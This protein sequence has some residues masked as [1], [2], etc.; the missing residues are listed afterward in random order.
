MKNST[1]SAQVANNLLTVLQGY[2]KGIR[3]IALLTLLLALGVTNAWGATYSLTPDKAQT[4]LSNT[5][6]ITS[7][8]SFTY[9]GVTWKMNQWNPSTL[10]IKTNQGSATSE[11]RFYNTSA[12]PGKIT[13]VVI[14]FSAMTVSDA[15]KLMFIGGT[16]E[17]TATSGGNAGTWN[18]SAKTLTWTPDASDNFTYFA[19]YQNGKAASGTNKLATSNAIVVTYETGES[20][21]TELTD[22]QFDWSAASAEATM[23]STF[24]NQPTLINTLGLSVS[25]SS[26]TPATATI[27][28]SGLVTLKAAGTT[29]ISATFAGGEVGGTTYA[30]KTVSY[31]LTVNP[32]PLVIEPIVGGIVDILTHSTFAATTNQ[33]TNFSGKQA[34]NDNHSDAVYAGKTARNGSATQYNIQLNTIDKGRIATTTTGGLAKRVYVRWA[35]Q[36]AN[37]NNRALYIYGS[38]DAFTGSETSTSATKIGTITFTTGAAEAYVDLTGDYKYILITGSG[39]IY[40]DEIH[41]TWVSAAGT[42]VTP[43]IHGDAEF[44][45]STEVSISTEDGY[46]VYYTLD[47]TEPTNASTEYTAPF[48]VDATTTVKAVAYDGATASDVVS[49]T[50]KKLQSLT[51]AEAAALC[52]STESTDKYVIRGY[53]TSI[54]YPYSATNTTPTFWM[55]DTKDGG[56]VMQAY[57][58]TPLEDADKEVIVGDQVE[59]IGKIKLYNSTPEVNGGTYTITVPNPKY[60]VNI[61]SAHG[62][63]TANPASAVEGTE[64]TLSVE[65]ESGWVFQSW[66]VTDASSNPIEV[67]DNKFTM[68]ASDVTVVANY[69]ES[70][71]PDAVLTL[72]ANGNQHSQE[73]YKVGET[74]ELPAT[75]VN[76]CVKQFVGWSTNANCAVAPEYAPGADFELTAT[77]HTLYA[78]YASGGTGETVTI[79]HNSSSTVNMTGENDANTY[80]GL[81]ANNWTIVSDKGAGSNHIG[82][83]KDGGMRLYYNESGSTTLTITAPSKVASIQ[84]ACA[85]NY[86]DALVKVDGNAVTPVDGVYAIDAETFVITNNSSTQVRIN[87]ITVTLAGAFTDYSTTCEVATPDSE[88]YTITFVTNGGSEVDP[89]TEQTAL[90]NPLPETTRSHYTFAGWYTDEG[91]TQAAVAGVA[92]TSNTT[93]YAKWTPITYTVS[94]DAGSGNYTS[95]DKT[96]NYETGITLPTATPCAYASTSGWSF[97][98]WSESTVSETTIRPVLHTGTYKPTKNIKLHAVYAKTEAGQGGANEFILSLQYES[99]TYYVGQTFSDSKLSAETEQANAAR[100]TIEDNYLHYEGGYISHVAEGSPNLTKKTD[101]AEAQGWTINEDGTNITFTSTTA[102]TS[103]LLAFHY[104][105][106]N[107]R[108]AA[109]VID[110][111]KY[112]YTFT[113]TSVSGGDVQVTTYNSNPSCEAPINPNWVDA[114]ISHAAIQVV[115]GSK[116]LLNAADP[117]GPATISFSGTDLVNP[118]TVTASSGFFVSTNKTEENTYQSEIT[119]NPHKE[120]GNIGK[121]QNVYVIAQA[122]AQSGNFTGTITLTGTDITD[123]SQV[124]KV[125]ADVTCTTYTITWSVNGDTKLIDPTT[126]YA[127]GDWT[128]PENPTYE[129]NGRE[130]VGWTTDEILQPQN[131]VPTTLYVEKRNF[132]T[133]ESDITFYAVFAKENTGDGNGTATVI[134]V[135]NRDLTGITETKYSN[136]S[137][138]TAT[139]SAVYAGNSA[140]GN[141]SIQL[142][143][144][145]SNSG[146][147]TTT[148]GGKAKEVTVVWNSNTSSGRT[149]NIYGKNS[150][151]SAATD[152]YGDNAG[153]LIGSITYNTSTTI[154]IDGDYEYIGIRSSNK[155]M[156]LTSIAITWETDDAGSGNATTYTSYT[157]SCADI[158]GIRIEGPTTT[159][160]NEG[161]TFVFDGKV[162]AINNDDSE[163]DVTNSPDLRFVYD[164]HKTG[165]QTVTVNYLGKSAT[166]EITINAVEK[167]QIT[168][169]VSGA[170]NT[171]LGPKEVAKETAIGTLPRPNSIPDGC[172][173]YKDFVGWTESNEVNADGSNIT[174]ITS[175]TVPSKNTTYYAVFATPSGSS[176][177]GDYVK[178]TETP[179]DFSGEYLIVYEDAKGD[180]KAPVAFNGGLTTLDA[181]S[182]TISVTITDNTIK[183][184]DATNAAKFTITKSADGYTIKSASGYFIGQTTNANANGLKSST[185]TY[186]SNNISINNDESAQVISGGTYLRYN[187]VSAINQGNQT[188]LRFRYFKSDTYTNQQPIAL[189]KKSGSSASYTDYTTGCH[190]VTITYYGFTGGYTTNCDGSDLNVITTRVN[191]AHTIPSCADITDPTTLG[192]KF[193]NLWK[194]QDGKVHQ[195]GETFIVTQDITLYAQWKLETTGDI[196]LP[197]DKEDLA[198]TDIVVTGGKTLTI[199]EGETIT[200]N[201]LTLKGGLLVEDDSVSGYA[202]PVVNIPTGATLVRKNT[203]INL[204]LVVNN[205]SWYPFAVPFEVEN[206]AA[207]VNYI[208]TTLKEYV[209]EVKGYGKYYRILE[210]NGALRAENGVNSAENWV[211]VGRTVKLMPGKGYAISAVPA[212]G[213]DTVTIRITMTV[214]DAWLANGEQESITVKEQ[215]TTRDT[216]PVTAHTGAAANEHPRHAGWNFVANPYLANFA[217]SEASNEGGSFIN[218]E[219][220]INNGEYS[221]GGEKVPYVTIPTYNFA[222]YYQVKLSD[223]TLSP[224][225]SFFVQVGESG[226]MTFGRQAAPASIAARNAEERPVK[227]DVDIT[228]SDNH[229][230]DQTGIIISDRYSEAYEIGRDL[231]KLFGSAYNLSVYTLMADNTPLAFQAL[232]IRSNMQVIPVGYRT[233]AQGE[234]TFRLNEATSSIDL[235][236]EQYEQLVLVDYQTGELTNLLISDYTFYSERTQADNRFAIY[237]VPR[238]NAPTDLPNAIG[239]DKEAQKIIHNGHLYILRD[240]NVYNGNGQIVK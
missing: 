51:C 74:V 168:W 200:I 47:G 127:G 105:N 170:T 96:G 156:Y 95:G 6:Y 59:V 104:N 71:A 185:T 240:G 40:M 198:T 165:T 8:T 227:M 98:G 107:P 28:A 121:L 161:D 49:T 206:T 111:D 2:T 191:S 83:N 75:I 112:P 141:S 66:T 76:D 174:Y 32:A 228:L 82:L 91:C 48:T 214:D 12:F 239:Q 11:W 159:T 231:E 34:T 72:M 203:T 70:V 224:A 30:E 16:S 225:Y 212:A 155:P 22:A 220:L 84:L 213:D 142:R 131:V 166:Y 110:G 150:A 172:N 120:G 50:L 67:T 190:D 116:T 31:T 42:V 139:S 5:S 10:Q 106:G 19:F 36:T 15:S 122:P 58:V 146:I 218:G 223:A 129:C 186:Y 151:Y 24:E 73:T 215:T 20:S 209:N 238:Q 176:G 23:P 97:V 162:Y 39:A 158:K 134:D 187:N 194:D 173:G 86:G 145:D 93:L 37:T 128:L 90:P 7:L 101:K 14:T 63:V 29:T 99:N 114:T 163:T 53:V 65:V 183:A 210:Y 177:D 216:V 160:F 217:G 132:P 54:P 61:T 45:E 87:S 232:A 103:R 140:G 229:S 78:V 88:T 109:Y 180:P 235:L 25:Y 85:N 79:K 117:N 135:L 207:N 57:K 18:N 62:T 208:N 26:S 201:S 46:K 237:A 43:T 211:H 234:Y 64:I 89:M 192:R 138:K 123:G 17:V 41:V 13:K 1:F 184:T 182:N 118:V 230:S 178:V 205:D 100:F 157:T 133:I 148:S 137:G 171:G 52:T 115:C 202:M 56:N 199:P 175:E 38:N 181:A 35:S 21:A 153:T 113:K 154:T 226:T 68:P 77:E 33:Y 195:P 94:F 189:Y 3:F 130:F 233:P 4:G 188:G 119:I 147:V 102:N 169:N 136:W 193:L 9:D 108:F 236:N 179:A 196:E 152:L 55:A 143:T 27:D 69:T 204:D 149:L 126:F 167:W 219:I 80:F 164:M 222:H 197:A 81:D 92:I 124:I 221:Y 125:T 60:N 144:E 44:V